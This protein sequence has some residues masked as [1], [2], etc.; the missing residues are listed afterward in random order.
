MKLSQQGNDLIKSFEGCRLKAYLC[1]A[2]VWTIG[3][4][5]TGPEVRK[6]LVWTRQQADD[7]FDVDTDRFE[8]CVSTELNGVTLA[9]ASYTADAEVARQTVRDMWP[10][11]EALAVA[12]FDAL[13]S[14]AFNI[15]EQA[16]SDSTLLRLLRAGDVMAAAE[17]FTRWNKAGG[18]FNPGLLARRT[19]EMRIF[20][21]GH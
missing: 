13:V 8:S 3:W 14:L 12:R 7:A 21:V 16:F 10:A 1:D 6:G 15:G 17:Q 9:K 18:K 5:H 20:L 4:G 2:G 19:K 11:V